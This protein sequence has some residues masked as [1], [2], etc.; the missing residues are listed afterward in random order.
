V[1]VRHLNDLTV[2]VISSGEETGDDC[3]AALETQDCTFRI[4][5][6]RDVTP[7]SAAFQAMPDRC[8][9]PYFVQVDADM[10]LRPD[11]VRKLYDAVRQSPYWVYRIA[12]TLYEEGFGI[13]G[14]VKCWKRSLFRFVSFHDCRTVDRELHNRLRW[15]GLRIKRIDEVVGVHRPR[16]SVFSLYLK[17]KSDIEKWRFLKRPASRYAMPLIEEIL[18]GD[19]ICGHRLLGAL[20]GALTG[21]QHLVR[22][23]N[24]PLEKERFDALLGL[25]GRFASLADPHLGEL[26][27][28]SLCTT[29]AYAFDDF[30]GTGVGKREPLVKI[31]GD[32][33][34]VPDARPE[35]FA[36]R[37][38]DIVDR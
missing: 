11:A 25:L 21:P 7:M 6:I 30:R 38:L 12:G 20:L 16:H 29:F 35:G 34:V 15:F 24:T 4:E 22:S 9:T 27:R 26:D 5:H 8:R 28:D 36:D 3:M 10:I 2:F 19:N 1:T 18:V 37:L 23:K 31:I 33:Y 13:G 32:I 17:T 14:A